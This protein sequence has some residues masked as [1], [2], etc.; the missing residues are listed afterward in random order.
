MDSSLLSLLFAIYAGL[1]IYNARLSMRGNCRLNNN[2]D[3]TH[4]YEATP[5]LHEKALIMLEE[6][7]DTFKTGK[8]SKAGYEK[9]GKAEEDEDDEGA[10]LMNNCILRYLLF[11]MYILFYLSLPRRFL[12][13][14]FLISIG[15]LSGL[16]YFTVWSISGISNKQRNTK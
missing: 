4:R 15:W 13:I 9:I 7:T 14:T 8:Q 2:N 12:I 3:K 16:S 6:M 10:G 5:L 1:M 11:P